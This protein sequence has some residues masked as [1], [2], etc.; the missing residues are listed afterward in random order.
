MQMGNDLSQTGRGDSRKKRDSERNIQC[1]TE[2][3]PSLEVPTASRMT[4]GWI[5][6]EQHCHVHFELAPGLHMK[7]HGHILE[8]HKMSD[9]AVGIPW[10]HTRAE[11]H[12]RGTQLEVDC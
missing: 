1:M 3:E 7:G 9:T 6:Q 10:V 4:E 12:R 2:Q 11:Y 8:L 5:S